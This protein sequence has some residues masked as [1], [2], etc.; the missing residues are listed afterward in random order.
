MGR[1]QR[2]IAILLVVIALALAVY[3]WTLSKEMVPEQPVTHMVV[4]AHQRIAAGQTL[5]ADKLRLLAFPERPPGSYGDLASV[6]GL[7]TPVDIAAGEALLAERIAPAAAVATLQKLN[8]GE[9]AVAIRVD[10]VI[11]VGNRLL[12]GDRVDLFASFRR[13]N[14]EIAD[15]QARL[16]LSDLRILAFGNQESSPEPARK[17]SVKASV[18]TPRTAVLAVPL[19]EVDKLALASET[20]RLLLALRPAAADAEAAVSGTEIYRLREL[21][22][23]GPLAAGPRP[24]AAPAPGTSVRVLH[25]LKESRVYVHSKTAGSTP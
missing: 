18:E 13:N 17:N 3:A 19:S 1:T 15:S 21:T 23:T 20:G 5:T 8:A 7:T 4:V 9:R 10:E 25:G 14:E 6:I 2:L 11:A 22:A 16:L 24:A 12:P